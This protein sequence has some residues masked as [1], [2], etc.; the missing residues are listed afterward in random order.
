M[1]KTHHVIIR[2]FLLFLAA[3]SQ[4]RASDAHRNN[5]F[6]NIKDPGIKW[7]KGLSWKQIKEKAGTENKYIFIDAFATWCAPCKKMEKE[8]FSNGAI[9]EFMNRKFIS[10]RVQFDSTA[11]DSEIVKAW[12]SV[13]NELR[14]EYKILSYPTYLFFDNNG[15]IIHKAIGFKEV[16]DFLSIIN[17]ATD[18]NKQFYTELR[19]L[20]NGSLSRREY[21]TLVESAKILGEKDI[22]LEIAKKFIDLFTDNDDQISS[23][24]KEEWKFIATYPKVMT[25]KNKL[26]KWSLFKKDS[27][28]KFSEVGIAKRIADAVI[29]KEEVQ[30]YVENCKAAGIRP[31]WGKM[32]KRILHKYGSEYVSN[33]VAV[34]RVNWYKNK[35][36]WGLYTKHFVELV[37]IRDIKRVQANW[38]G[39]MNLN[40][41]AWEVFLRSNVKKNKKE[42]KVAIKWMDKCFEID[43]ALKMPI[44]SVTH[45]DTKANL[46]YKLGK[47]NEAIFLQEKAL[48]IAQQLNRSNLINEFSGKL[49]KMRKGF[50][51]W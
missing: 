29:N 30:L 21:L 11:A 36:E 18:P 10:V 8:T 38:Q 15:N 1:N 50:P 48:E 5:I 49:E 26:F 47:H 34:A 13:A 23:L 9:G 37:E 44:F 19:E 28:D 16:N 43:D 14:T 17:D 12:H 40:N 24:T 4:A 25:S 32:A 22:E 2:S 33:K 20:K 7:T 42:I 27:V 31:N 39:A 6:Q 41:N 45:Y 51:T 46:L 3:L 35:K